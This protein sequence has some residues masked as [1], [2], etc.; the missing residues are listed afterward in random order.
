MKILNMTFFI[1][2]F[3][4]ST[5]IYSQDLIKNVDPFIGTGLHGHTFTG[6]IV[7]FGM[8]QLSP[9]NGTSG[10]DWCYG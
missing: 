9:D 4:M 7:L 8:V 6:A 5:N 3:M 10:W 2:L 1:M